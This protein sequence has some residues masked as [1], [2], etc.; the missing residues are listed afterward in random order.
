LN[1]ISS[2]D[3]TAN[4][5]PSPVNFQASRCLHS[6]DKYS[7][8]ESCLEVCP[9]EA[10][11]PGKPPEWEPARCE[12]CFACLTVCPT[13]AFSGDSTFAGIR[14]SPGEDELK[15]LLACA[16]RLE[17]RTIALVCRRN[18][19]LDQQAPETDVSLQFQGCLAGISAGMYLSLLA[20]GSDKV[21]IRMDACQSCPWKSL[22]SQVINQVSVA[23]RLLS[24]TGRPGS[25]KIVEWDQLQARNHTPVWDT[26][27]PP[28]S[29]RD[30]FRMAGILAKVAEIQA[31]AEAPEQRERSAPREHRRL[32][33]AFRKVAR[34]MVAPE[35]SL[36]GMGFANLQLSDACTACGACARACPTG[37]IVYAENED[38]TV[39]LLAFNP[40]DCNG[41]QACLHA[42]FAGAIQVD[43]SPTFAD[44][45]G[46]HPPVRLRAGRLTRC[47]RCQLPFAAVAG[48]KLCP[49]CE[50]R[51]IHP[52][53]TLPPQLF[54]G[55]TVPG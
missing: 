18:P 53:G 29:R 37:A 51:R 45:F 9:A 25:L 22:K 38:Q 52:F 43:R 49:V 35:T 40:L 44:I 20:T 2:I 11:L 17:Q 39:F 1:L 42:C 47:Q 12:H 23:E 41:C 6:I 19:N 28:L 21:Y 50:Y 24:A 15:D 8:C 3:R 54:P 27:N 4:D 14:N 55:K 36:A 46:A 26:H 48:K 7:N 10:I 31:L 32:V 16:V 5:E 33:N 13:Q 30:L 34:V